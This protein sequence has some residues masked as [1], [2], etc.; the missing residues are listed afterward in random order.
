MG[1]AVRGAAAA[2]ALALA[3]G[4]FWFTTKDEG[5]TLRKNV[6][7]LDQRMVKQEESVD[8]RVK[9]LDESLDKATKLLTRNSADVGSEVQQL[10]KD[11]SSLNGQLQDMRRQVEGMRAEV[12]ALKQENAKLRADYEARLVAAEQR[13]ASLDGGKGTAPTP[14]KPDGTVTSPGGTVLDKDSLFTRARKALDEGQLSDAR[15]DYAD[16]VKRFPKD[17]RADDA[18]L[19]LGE[20]AFREK[21]YDKAITEFQKVFDSYPDGDQA[22]RALFRAGE[23]SAVLKWCVDAKAYFDVLIKKYPKSKLVK[24]AKTRLDYLKKNAKKKDVCST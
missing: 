4:C 11:Q 23:T 19:A 21:A 10:S 5:N 22:D 18:Q 8:E 14:P 15:R 1:I 17:T 3:P 13:I 9:K 20:I 24:D 2:L 6:A 12:D 7:S 16:F